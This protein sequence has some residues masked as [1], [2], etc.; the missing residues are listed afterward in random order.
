MKH[1]L[2]HD[3]Y[4]LPNK[5]RPECH[6][7]NHSY[8]SMYGRLNWELPAQTITS[9]FGSIG[10]GRYMHPSRTRALTAHE[11]ARLQGFPDYFDFSAVARRADLAT[12]IGNA[13]PPALARE[14]VAELIPAVVSMLG[15]ETAHRGPTRLY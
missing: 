9:G 2:D 15:P 5:E 7:D 6:R 12:M 1:L 3:L 11:A 8:K 14:I 4:D 10:Q 13:V